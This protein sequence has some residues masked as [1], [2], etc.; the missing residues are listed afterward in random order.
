MDRAVPGAPARLQRLL[1][2]T[3]RPTWVVQWQDAGSWQLD[4]GD[5]TGRLLAR[6]YRLAATVRGHR[7]YRRREIPA[8]AR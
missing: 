8:G 4:P 2:S 3:R 5:R 1:G 6:G 7:I